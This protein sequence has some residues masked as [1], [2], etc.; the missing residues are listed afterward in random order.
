MLKPRKS[1]SPSN[2]TIHGSQRGGFLLSAA[3]SAVRVKRCEGDPTL[4]VHAP[5]FQWHRAEDMS[6]ERN[7]KMWEGITSDGSDTE[8]TVKE[9]TGCGPQSFA[10]NWRQHKNTHTTHTRNTDTTGRKNE[11]TDGKIWGSKFFHQC[12][13]KGDKNNL[14][15]WKKS[16]W[17]WIWTVFPSWKLN[18]AQSMW[19]IGNWHQLSTSRAICKCFKFHI[20]CVCSS[21]GH[22]WAWK[23]FLT[24]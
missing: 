22:S 3:C 6:H 15:S 20:W 24:T 5:V 18:S 8:I 10:R 4:H 16:L 2:R 7:T 1:H 9:L 21:I 14:D 11:K 13:K 17:C 23:T 12:L 19:S